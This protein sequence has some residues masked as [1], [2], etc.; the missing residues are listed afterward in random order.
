[1]T[2]NVNQNTVRS[3]VTNESVVTVLGLANTT[4]T[5][6]TIVT[7]FGNATRNTDNVSIDIG[8]MVNMSTAG[9]LSVNATVFQDST[10][11]VSY[12]YETGLYVTDNRSRTI[13]RI[14]PLLFVLAVLA[15]SIWVTTRSG[16]FDRF[17]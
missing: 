12:T 11:N 16:L 14:V 15:I 4:H 13:L 7:F 6:Q 10:Y 3:Q 17:N 5:D 9:E 8:G 2:D 1:V